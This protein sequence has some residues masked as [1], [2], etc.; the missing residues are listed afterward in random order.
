VLTPPSLRSSL[1][2]ST[3]P[4]KSTPRR[5]APCL[6]SPC[7]R[8][9]RSLSSFPPSLP[10]SV[11][12]SLLP[13]FYPPVSHPSPPS[14]SP[15]LLPPQP[16]R[17][18]SRPLHPLPRLQGQGTTCLHQRGAGREGGREGGYREEA[19]VN[20]KYAQVKTRSRGRQGEERGGGM[21]P[22]RGMHESGSKENH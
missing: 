11:L 3:F 21:N 8:A 7:T 10:P 13:T 12:L 17:V 18:P 16:A 22:S 9:G 14:L 20:C 19:G 1:P 6:T 5:P 4:S 15:S 2:P